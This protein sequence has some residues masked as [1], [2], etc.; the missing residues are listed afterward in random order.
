MTKEIELT[1]GKFVLVD[2]E[3]YDYMNQWGWYAHKQGN[4]FYAKRIIRENNHVIMVHMHREIVQCPEGKYVD[5]INGN[6]LDNRKENLRI[7]NKAENGRNRPKQ[8]NNS[9]G[10]KGVG[11]DK[12]KSRWRAQI[13]VNQK[14]KFIGRYDT[15]EDAAKAYDQE[16]KR[17]FG[18]FAYLNFPE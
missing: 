9:S 16:A 18:E 7:C 8:I 5:H 15:K 14:N 1:Q 6:G 11:W 13:M 3:D 17:L 12:E 10:Y 2:D 4:T